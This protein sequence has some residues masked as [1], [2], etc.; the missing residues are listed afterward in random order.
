[1]LSPMPGVTPEGHCQPGTDPTPRISHAEQKLATQNY[2]GGSRRL[3][4]KML[5][6]RLSIRILSKAYPGL[7]IL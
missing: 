7:G 4:R 3:Y 1:M 5:L 6:A 2:L